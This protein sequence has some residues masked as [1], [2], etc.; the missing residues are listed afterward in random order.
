ML[1]ENLTYGFAGILVVVCMALAAA[2]ISSPWVLAGL[3]IGSMLIVLPFGA[4][5]NQMRK[6]LF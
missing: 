4:I 2:N 5:M 6:H 1:G 3:I